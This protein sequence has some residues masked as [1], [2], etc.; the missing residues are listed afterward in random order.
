MVT[1]TGTV[2]QGRIA[3]IGRTL[4]E[5]EKED[6]GG[7]MI[8]VLWDGAW[9]KAQGSSEPGDLA[10]LGRLE[11]E[12]GNPV[13]FTVEAEGDGQCSEAWPTPKEDAAAE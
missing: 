9:H 8:L 3:E 13:T 6:G 5:Y 11:G 2:Y 4:I 7:T 10:Y 1:K 12:A